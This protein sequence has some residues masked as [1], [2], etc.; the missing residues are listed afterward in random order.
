MRGVVGWLRPDTRLAFQRQ[1]RQTH[2]T[3]RMQGNIFAD[4]AQ[5]HKLAMGDKRCCGE[6][7]GT[8]DVRTQVKFAE[9]LVRNLA[10]IEIACIP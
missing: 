1:V 10:S 6:F 9:I 5:T 2:R 4:E 3:H 8:T 7:S